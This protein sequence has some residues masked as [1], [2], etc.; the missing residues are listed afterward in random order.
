MVGT[1]PIA[2]VLAVGVGLLCCSL[3]RAEE[4]VPADV[5]DELSRDAESSLAEDQEAFSE[6][7]SQCIPPGVAARTTG[8]EWFQ[9]EKINFI[10]TKHL[11]RHTRTWII[12]NSQNITRVYFLMHGDGNSDYSGSTASDRKRMA[13]AL[14]AETNGQEGALVA[15]PV[16]K[17]SNWPV[18]Q[19][20][21]NGKTLLLMFRKL[22]K[23]LG[24]DGLKFEMFSLSGG[25]RANHALL[26][27]INGSY[28][29]DP[30][31]K[32][33]V[34]DHLRGIHDGDSLCY[35]IENFRNQYISAIRRFPQIRF[36]FIHNTSGKMKYVQKHHN[37]IAKTIGNRTYKWGGSLS[38]QQGRLRFWSSKTHWTAWQGQFAKVF[39]P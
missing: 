32:E 35:S 2:L 23:A 17:S 37:T 31:V 13:Q 10:G 21:K 18:F 12:G 22:E 20:G 36:S 29:S 14:E 6:D 30:D 19:G 33:F 7:L 34:D 4:G 5:G 28:D 8:V 1:R 15:Y 3:L 9:G 11:F 27:M 24:Y 38:L 16:C 39:F 26:R 25:G